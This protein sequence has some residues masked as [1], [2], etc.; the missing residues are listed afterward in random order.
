M[1]QCISQLY[2]TGIDDPRLSATEIASL[3]HVQSVI[4]NELQ[5][6]CFTSFVQSS[7]YLTLMANAKK[8]A[9]K[10]TTG[11]EHQ[12]VSSTPSSTTIPVV[13]VDGKSEEKRAAGASPSPP[14]TPS[15]STTTAP[16]SPRAAT[17]PS[18]NDDDFDPRAAAAAS[19]AK[20]A[21][22]K[23]VSYLFD[24][25]LL[26]RSYSIYDITWNDPICGYG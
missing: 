2:E 17:S 16:S 9:D 10:S 1:M 13:V 20:Q 7:Q 22:A 8:L 19:A 4:V 6:S 3:L 26:L 21:E 24:R 25:M 18:N 11:V 14:S 15:R 5:V 23:G 12:V